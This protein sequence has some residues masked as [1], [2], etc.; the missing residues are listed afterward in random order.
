MKSVGFVALLVRS[1]IA[2]LVRTAAPTSE[3][4]HSF[5]ETEIEL[6]VRIGRD[7]LCRTATNHLVESKRH[8][9]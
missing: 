4:P 9:S 3:R 7:G 8:H 6:L 2:I 1:S 5:V